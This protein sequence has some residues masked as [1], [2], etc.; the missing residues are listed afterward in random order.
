MVINVNDNV[1][2]INTDGTRRKLSGNLDYD[3]AKE[4]LDCDRIDVCATITCDVILIDEEGK[5]KG[6]SMNMVATNLYL[7]GRCNLSG[8]IKNP[9]L[10]RAI[11]MP[12]EKYPEFMNE[13]LNKRIL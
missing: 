6:F 5:E 9:I 13:E 1:F 12:K 11:F 7:L 2:V 3:S 4:L 10:G 8:I